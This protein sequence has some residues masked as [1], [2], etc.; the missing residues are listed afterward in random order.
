MKLFTV[1]LIS[2]FVLSHSADASQFEKAQQHWKKQEYKSVIDILPPLRDE[3]FGKRVDVDYMLATSMCRYKDYHV[4]GRNYLKRILRVYPLS[5]KNYDIIFNELTQCPVQG[6]PNLIAFNSGRGM[7]GVSGKSFYFLGGANQS[8][9]GNPLQVE[10]AIA[11]SE[12]D[13]RLVAISESEIATQR[14]KRRLKKLG[15]NAKVFASGRF[16]VGSISNHTQGE[17]EKIV[18]LLNRALNFLQTSYQFQLPEQF[19]TI[20]LVPD[21]LKLRAFGDKL[22]GLN[23]NRSTIGY[24]FRDDLSLAAVVNGPYVGTL[25]HELAHLLVRTN[26]GDVPPWLDEGLAALY[27]VSRQEGD[28]LRGL[29]NWRG[30][31]LD[32]YFEQYPVGLVRL[33]TMDW[34]D[35]D[36]RKIAKEQQAVNHALARYWVL[37]LQDKELLTAVYSAFKNVTVEQITDNYQAEVKGLIKQATGQSLMQ[38]EQDFFA[39]LDHAQL[40]ITREQVIDIQERLTSLGYDVGTI[41]GLHGSL[42]SKAIKEFQRSNNIEPDGRIDVSLINLLMSKTGKL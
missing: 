14:V 34:I 25:K 33:M 18:S 21:G 11:Q 35:F 29:P 42:T 30:Q 16:V 27:E 8:I 2:L 3:F 4:G 10:R 37:Y 20:Y 6:K 13:Q 17:L 36:A 12:I 26:F 1:A 41:D 5:N 19:F 22:H 39:W 23:V 15:Y 40:P 7:A 38:L 9:G 32:H 28:Y 31:V 24:S